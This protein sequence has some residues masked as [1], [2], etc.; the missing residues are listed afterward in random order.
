MWSWIVIGVLY[1]IVI[2]GFRIVG[3]I[4]SAMDAVRE[5]G[6]ASTSGSHPPVSSS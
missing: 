1:V 2:C 5:W 6:H 3:G 4:G